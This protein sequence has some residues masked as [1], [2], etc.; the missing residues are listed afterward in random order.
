MLHMMN[1]TQSIDLCSTN[2]HH[3]C[4]MFLPSDLFLGSESCWLKCQMFLS[5]KSPA[6]QVLSTVPFKSFLSLEACTCNI[7]TKPISWQIY[8]TL[9]MLIL[10]YYK[11]KMFDSLNF[12][13]VSLSQ[14]FPNPNM[15]ISSSGSIY[16]IW[17]CNCKMTVFHFNFWLTHNYF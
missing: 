3:V 15:L 16:S 13:P 4:T 12:T 11:F 1:T 2:P 7:M 17:K 14:G 5:L 6:E 9:N 10:Q 8:H